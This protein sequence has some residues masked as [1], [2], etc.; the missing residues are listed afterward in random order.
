ME[1]LAYSNLLKVLGMAGRNFPIATPAII[2]RIT[3]NERY[4]SKKPICLLTVRSAL[5][6]ILFLNLSI[7]ILTLLYKITSGNI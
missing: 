6:L 1:T 7:K 3:H 2:Q 5:H 4:L